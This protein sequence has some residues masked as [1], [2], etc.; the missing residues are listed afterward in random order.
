MLF[1]HEGCRL[2]AVLWPLQQLE[3]SSVLPLSSV[4]LNELH[5]ISGSSSPQVPQR[6]A[7]LAALSRPQQPEERQLLQRSP[8]HGLRGQHRPNAR[9][10]A[11]RSQDGRHSAALPA[12]PVTPI[13]QQSERRSAL[14]C[15]LP[16]ASRSKHSFKVCSGL[17]VLEDRAV[18]GAHP[19]LVAREQ[20]VALPFAH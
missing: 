4:L 16:Q 5:S 10:V 14:H 11:C 8:L 7:L 9:A 15:F 13:H 1:G 19:F 12:C 20:A 3:G 17:Q 2:P 6:P 18:G